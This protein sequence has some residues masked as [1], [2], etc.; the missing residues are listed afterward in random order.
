LTP[1]RDRLQHLTE[2]AVRP[3]DP[4]R[5]KE[6]LG[7][8]AYG[9][10]MALREEGARLLEGR[11]L[12]NVNS[13]AKGGGVAEMLASLL[14]YVAGEGIDARWVVIGGSPEFFRVTKRIH[15]VLH[16]QPGD[17][18]PL[19]DD[20]SR[21]YEAGLAPNAEELAQVIGPD[22]V[23]I[24]HDPQTV[25]L[26]PALA[27]TA[28]AVV[29]RCH[30]GVDEPNDLARAG[31][32]FLRPFLEAAD[33]YVFSR[34]AYTWDGL[35]EGKVATIPPSIDAFSPKNQEMEHD[36]V[37]AIVRAAGLTDDR[38]RLHPIGRLA[39]RRGGR[40]PRE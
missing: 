32:D 8:D 22:D 4:E 14:A 28:A 12:W 13:A 3:L 10:F 18:G 40:C 7:A 27:R 20:E 19:R 35:D 21:T 15:N 38:S 2:V 23:V 24:L 34:E 30:I 39:V 6:V 37:R 11:V 16:G 36:V 31:W 25:G 33:A 26:A 5:F 1:S 17:G 9:Q 29:W